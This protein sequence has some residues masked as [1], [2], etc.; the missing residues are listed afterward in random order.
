M[1][2]GLSKNLHLKCYIEKVFGKEEYLKIK[3]SPT[4]TTWE[5][6]LKLLM[7]SYEKAIK[8]SIEVAPVSFYNEV[9][10][11]IDHHIKFIQNHDNK[12]ELFSSM[13]A[14]QSELIFLLLGNITTKKNKNPRASWNL[15][16]FRSTQI[17]QTQEQE[18]LQIKNAV[19]RRFSNEE[20]EEIIKLW[21]T[22]EGSSK[23]K[24]L[25]LWIFHN[26]MNNIL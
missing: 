8:Q 22:E 14:L 16:A 26:K 12:E 18:Y 15:S 23:S 11:A 2:Q 24:N 4:L 17:I 9:T 13:V 1:N 21:H 19:E 10:K 5:K 7:Q 25:F 20:I 3:E 6:T